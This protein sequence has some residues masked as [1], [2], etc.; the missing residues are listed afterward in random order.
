[1]GKQKQ[2]NVIFRSFQ[3]INKKLNAR[4]NFINYQTM[5]NITKNF[6]ST[7]V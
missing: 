5:K 2:G 7:N 1:M 4:K 6:F 3:M